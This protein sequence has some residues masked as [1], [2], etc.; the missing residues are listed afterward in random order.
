[1]FDDGI[2]L[3]TVGGA[4]LAFLESGSLSSDSFSSELSSFIDLDAAVERFTRGE[5]F[6]LLAL[7]EAFFFRFGD[8]YHQ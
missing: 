1:M 6:L 3:R 5:A 4:G 7:F 2:E 8:S